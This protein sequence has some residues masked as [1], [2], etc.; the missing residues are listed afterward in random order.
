MLYDAVVLTAHANLPPRASLRHRWR[1][2]VA[3]LCGPVAPLGVSQPR[4]RQ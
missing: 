3:G 4:K 2:A 1:F